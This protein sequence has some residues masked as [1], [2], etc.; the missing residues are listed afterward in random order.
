MT[1]ETLTVSRYIASLP[2]DR[3]AAIKAVRKVI[4]D[5]LGPGFK[6]TIQYNCIGWCVPHSVYPAGYHC[7]PKEPLPY[8]GLASQKN[9]MALYLF[10]TY[11]SETEQERFRKAWLKTGRKLD[12]GKS[13]VR[14]RKLEDVPLEVVGDVVSRS[15]LEKFVASYEKSIAGSASRRGK[16]STAK[17]KTVRRK[18]AT[19]K[20]TLR[21]KAATKKKT[22]RKKAATKKKTP[23][24]KTGVRAR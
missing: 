17:K 18:A 5:N 19:K 11:T 9:H 10:C 16:T 13:C 23:R 15:T 12:M 6:E 21:K 2:A 20:K 4:N 1:T 7:N 14:F 8:I 24:K 22:L 3:R